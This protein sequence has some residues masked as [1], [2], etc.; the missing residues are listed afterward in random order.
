MS[1]KLKTITYYSLLIFAI[2]LTVNLTVGLHH[3]DATSR[4][5]YSWLKAMAWL[6]AAGRHSTVNLPSTHIGHCDLLPGHHGHRLEESA[7]GYSIRKTTRLQMLTSFL[8]RFLPGATTQKRTSTVLMVT[9]PLLVTRNPSQ[10][11]S[12]D[13]FQPEVGLLPGFHLDRA[14]V[15]G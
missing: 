14:V 10:P 13:L 7:L 4:H 12:L 1:R 11:R 3:G 9:P 15:T 5:S 2:N 6:L 8:P